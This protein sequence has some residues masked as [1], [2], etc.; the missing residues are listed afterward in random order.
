MADHDKHDKND[1]DRTIAALFQSRAEA[2]ATI[3]AL[4]KAKYS[5]TWPRLHERCGNGRRR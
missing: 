1:Q 4:H 3:A 2:R 5:H